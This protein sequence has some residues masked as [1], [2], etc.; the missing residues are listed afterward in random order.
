MKDYG[1][2]KGIPNMICEPNE[3][4]MD[5]FEILDLMVRK[6]HIFMFAYDG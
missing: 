5:I 3:S 6:I 2:I 1:K 4:H